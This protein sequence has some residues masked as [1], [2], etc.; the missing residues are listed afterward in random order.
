MFVGRGNLKIE[1]SLAQSRSNLG[2]CQTRVFT[3]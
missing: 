3:F 1:M 2:R